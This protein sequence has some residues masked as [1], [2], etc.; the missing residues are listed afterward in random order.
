MDPSLKRIALAVRALIMK[1]DPDIVEHLMWGNPTYSK[2]R[3]VFWIYALSKQWI[4]LGFFRG[5][6]LIEF[7]QRGL[8]EGTGSNMRHIKIRSIRDID[9]SYLTKLLRKALLLDGA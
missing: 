9:R 4:N 3:D 1:V 6:D 7:D 8:I 2:Q 5:A